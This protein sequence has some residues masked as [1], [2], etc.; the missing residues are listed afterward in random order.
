MKNQSPL[1]TLCELAQKAVEQASTQLGQARLSYQNAEQQLTMLLTY[2][3]EYRVRL[4]DTLSNGMASSSWQ[5]YQQFIQTLE[6]AIDQ[7][8]NQLAQWNVK[9]E[10][11][12]KH[13][14]E[15][16]QRLNAFETLQERAAS[17]ARLQE[18]RLDQ[19]LMDEFAQRASQRSL[20][21]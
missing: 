20:N 8:R 13:W 2:Q 11:A 4:N 21:S 1:V 18:N 19:K 5:N 7:H 12:V 9:V 10:Q 6:Q 3:D 16:Q 14:Q 15:K 17:T